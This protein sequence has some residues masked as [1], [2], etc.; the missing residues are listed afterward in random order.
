MTEDFKTLLEILE[1]LHPKSRELKALREK[2]LSQPSTT[3][4][5]APKGPVSRDPVFNVEFH[6]GATMEIIGWRAI[7]D[8]VGVGEHSFRCTMSSSRYCVIR[9]Y[10]DS[11]HKPRFVRITRPGYFDPDHPDMA[12]DLK[13]RQPQPKGPRPKELDPRI[14]G[15]A[16]DHHVP[17]PPPNK[18]RGHRG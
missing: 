4:S 16:G 18:Y 12:V 10:R 14:Y 15:S 3:Y 6:D 13:T 11:D 8:F 1:K 9:Q 2:V 17:S 7:A 5:L